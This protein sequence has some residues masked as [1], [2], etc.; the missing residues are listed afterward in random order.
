MV[1]HCNTQP[2]HLD[3][4]TM[5]DEGMLITN[6]VT[7][8]ITDEKESRMISGTNLVSYTEKI[9]IN[10]T[11]Y[12][13]NIGTS[14]KKA[15]VSAMAQVNILRH[16]ERL[17]LSSIYGMSVKNLQHINH[18]QSRLPSCNTWIFCSVSSTASITLVI[19]FLIYRLK[20]KRQQPSKT[21]ESGDDFIFRQGGVNT[22]KSEGCDD[23]PKCHPRPDG[24]TI[25]SATLSSPVTHFALAKA[26]CKGQRNARRTCARWVTVEG[27]ELQT[28]RG[29]D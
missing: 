17:S 9:K 13:N 27:T 5:I 25:T 26:M 18:L 10:G 2:G 16:L 23:P 21:I 24:P 12:V 20:A 29:A 3:P 19:I 6:D 15:A 28:A 8:N 1:A 22:S 14:K 11:L 4:V 7:I